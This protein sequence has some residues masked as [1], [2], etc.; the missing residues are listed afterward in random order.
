ML[1]RKLRI[2][3]AAQDPLERAAQEAETRWRDRYAEA[4]SWLLR[5]AL[6]GHRRGLLA[7]AQRPEAEVVLGR[8]LAAGVGYPVLETLTVPDR[9]ASGPL[10]ASAASDPAA[11]AGAAAL[12]AAVRYAVADAAVRAVAAEVVI[13][14][15]RLRGIEDRWLPALTE[16]HRAVVAELDEQERADGARLRWATQRRG[17]AGRLGD[18]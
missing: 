2:L 17:S 9:P 5:A 11:A 13:T 3:R 6:L 1:D 15:R 12:E 4:D 18:E 16:R 10:P 7:A 8:A 14:R